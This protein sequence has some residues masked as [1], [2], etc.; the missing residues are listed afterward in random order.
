MYVE[1]DSG[2]RIVCGHPGEKYQIE[3]VLG[4][5]FKK[6]GF[7][8]YNRPVKTKWWWSKKKKSMYNLI[9]RRTGYNSECI[10]LDCLNRLEL[11]L[12]DEESEWRA[13]YGFNR[14]KDERVCDRCRSINVKTVFELIDHQ[15]PKC[16]TGKIVIAPIYEDGEI[17]EM[18]A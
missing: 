8:V 9:Q 6:L 15:C 11:D 1:N 3:K 10:C 13:D 16:K 7:S 14:A 4:V 2:Q 17:V 5:D 12:G 18:W